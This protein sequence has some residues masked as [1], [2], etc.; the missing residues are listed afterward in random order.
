MKWRE[1]DVER[2]KL[3]KLAI[4]WMQLINIDRSLETLGSV[5]Y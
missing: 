2:K 5:G 3:K 1:R 4:L